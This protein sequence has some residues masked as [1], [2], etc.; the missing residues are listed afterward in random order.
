MSS[1]KL[2]L[3]EDDDRDLST[4]E[5]TVN[6]YQDEEQREIELVVSRT[7]EDAFSK[8]DRSYD[9]AII[10]ITI[11]GDDDAGNQVIERIVEE[12]LRLPTLILTGTPGSVDARFAHI[13]TYTKG[14]EEASFDKL[15]KGL[16]SIYDTGLTRILGGRGTIESYLDEVFHRILLPQIDQWEKYG[17]RD[18]TSTEKALLRHTLNHLLQLIDEEIVECFPEE[19][20]LHPSLSEEIRTGSILREI[21]DGTKFVVLSPDCDI[22]VREDGSRNT[23]RVLVAEIV[24]PTALISWYDPSQLSSLGRDRKNSLRSALENNRGNQ[25]HCLPETAFFPLGFINFRN[26]TTCKLEDLEERFCTPPICQISPPFVKD[27]VS[28]FSSYY[29]RQGQ[30]DIDFDDFVAP[31]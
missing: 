11:D 22:V 15:L 9:G 6:R 10:D 7:L 8:L 30:P 14:E 13:R 19:F 16:L 1:F 17:Q 21:D 27:I 25:Y 4:Y 24:P 2:L 12:K 5:D 26:L 20:Y 28:R 3:V 23:D 18:S 29:A 31:P